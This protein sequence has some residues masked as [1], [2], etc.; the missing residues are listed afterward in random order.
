LVPVIHWSMARP[1]I[2]PRLPLMVSSIAS[3]GDLAEVSLGSQRSVVVPTPGVSSAGGATQGAVGV[4]VV[5]AS[6]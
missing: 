4:G 6:P 3:M 1:A 2:T 5:G